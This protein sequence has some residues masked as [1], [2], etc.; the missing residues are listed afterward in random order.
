MTSVN[1]HVLAEVVPEVVA[2]K[3]DVAVFY[4][5]NNEVVGPYGPGTPFTAWVRRPSIVWLDKKLRATRT[6][7]LLEKLLLSASSVPKSWG[8][9]QMFADLKVPADSP[10]LQDA[11]RAFQQNLEGMVVA[12]LDAGSRVVLC[13]IAVNLA[14]WGPSGDE[15]L[16]AGSSAAGDLERGRLLLSE[17]R[18]AEASAI[19]ESAALAAPDSAQVQFLLGR[20]LRA[21]GRD[22][23]AA[24]AFRRARDLDRHRFRA[25]TRINDIIRA[26]AARHAGRGVVLVDADRDLV[27]D[28]MPGKGEFAEHVHFTFE[29]MRRLGVLVAG[30]L[31]PVLPSLGTPQPCGDAEIS[32]L[33]ERI[34]FT[35]FDEVLLATVARDV[36]QMDIFRS[37]PASAEALVHLDALEQSLRAANP[38]DAAQLRSTYQRASALRPGDPRLEASYAD[39]LSRMGLSTEAAAAGQRVLERKPT[40]F[41]G[42]RFMADAAKGR[43]DAAQA[44]ELYL[45]ALDSYRLIPDARKNLGDLAR[46]SGDLGVAEDHYDNA[47]R[48]DAGNVGAALALAE[49]EANSSRRDL[50]RQTL[51]GAERHN[52]QDASVQVALARLESA[53]GNFAEARGHW[54]QALGM[55]AE[56]SPRDLLRLLAEKFPPAESFAAFSRYEGRFGDEHDLYNNYAW[57]LATAP[58]PTLRDPDAAV[59]LAQRAIEL[60]PKPN[61]YYHG[62]LA[63]ASAAAGDFAAARSNMQTALELS[64]DNP[65]LRAQ[66]SAMQKRFET[67]QPYI[68]SPATVSP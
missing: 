37:R 60:S 12:L 29:G 21:A 17:G 51:L 39:Y 48:M 34:F 38:L 35:P 6:Y 16:P 11:Y 58:E 10:A 65:E 46:A 42:Y 68:E 56:L 26:V 20:A 4:M 44:R 66:F 14:D 52:P 64:S 15:P 40:Y 19:L 25:D 23:E 54:E 61:A 27:G 45:R 43:G 53:E 30:A 1:S 55:D 67:G 59:R 18:A 7:Q 24:A 5:G 3:P 41:E 62:T 31:P 8:G 47:F 57:L 13:T 28:T 2:Q 9:F 22:K 50:A 49:M 63:A 33:R 36:G 32:A